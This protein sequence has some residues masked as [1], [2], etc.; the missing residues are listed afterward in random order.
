MFTLLT[1][2]A[3][4]STSSLNIAFFNERVALHDEFFSLSSTAMALVSIMG[5]YITVYNY[6]EGLISSQ[7]HTFL[8]IVSREIIYIIYL[9]KSL[10]I[11]YTN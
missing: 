10:H 5:V 3:Q 9:I 2:I 4:K 1:W 7:Y 6:A 8:R 11:V